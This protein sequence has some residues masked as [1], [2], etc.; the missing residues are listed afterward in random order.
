MKK[1]LTVLVFILLFVPLLNVYAD[2]DNP[3]IYSDDF[4]QYYIL[5]HLGHGY[6]Y[7]ENSYDVVETAEHKGVISHDDRTWIPLKD[8]NGQKIILEYNGAEY[9]KGKRKVPNSFTYTTGEKLYV[10][11]ISGSCG[12]MEFDLDPESKYLKLA[13]NVVFSKDGKRLMSYA[14][15]DGRE[16]YK[17]P[18]GTEII[19][20]NAFYKCNNIKEISVPDSVREINNAFWAMDSLEKINIPPLVE[21]LDGAFTFNYKLNE[22]HIPPDSKLKKIVNS[23]FVNTEISELTLPSFDVE[24][25][26]DVFVGCNEKNCVTLKSYVQPDASAEQVSSGSYRIKWDKISNASYYE[27][28]QK[29][30][31]GTYKLLKTVKGN[32]IKINKLKSGKKYI[33]AVKPYAEIKACGDGGQYCYLDLPEYFTVEGT[34]SE[35][36]TVDLK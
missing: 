12:F 34:M 19:D 8:K 18:D 25:D 21:A 9:T 1:I 29:K 5:E 36:V 23:A 11:A 22:V 15:Y 7:I 28:Y 33:F 31:D 6:S 27:V 26:K 20:G 14:R 32:S 17:I 35:D 13:D 24:I 30:K 2:N 16:T 4:M 3:D 10:T